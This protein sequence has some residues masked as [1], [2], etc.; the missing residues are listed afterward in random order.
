MNIEMGKVQLR[1]IEPRSIE[2]ESCVKI[3]FGSQPRAGQRLK[4][5]VAGDD[6]RMDRWR[7][8][9]VHRRVGVDSVRPASDRGRQVCAAIF[10]FGSQIGVAG[11]NLIDDETTALSLDR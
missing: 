1:T 5:D 10:G 7:D 9:V 2:G 3:G 4:I 6:L 8:E 11:A